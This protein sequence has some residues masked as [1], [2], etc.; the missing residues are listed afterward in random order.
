VVPTQLASGPV[1][2]GAMLAAVDTARA[3]LLASVSAS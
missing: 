2:C 1:L 3:E